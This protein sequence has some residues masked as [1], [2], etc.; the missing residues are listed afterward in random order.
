VRRASDSRLAGT[1]PGARDQTRSPLVAADVVGEDPQRA[2]GQPGH[3]VGQVAGIASLDESEQ[4][5]QPA[6]R[7]AVRASATDSRTE[8]HLLKRVG[9]G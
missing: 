9:N 3:A 6:Q 5:P 1:G 8:G 7:A 2:G 4:V